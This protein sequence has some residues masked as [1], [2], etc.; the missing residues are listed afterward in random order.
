ME[1]LNLDQGFPQQFSA[2]QQGIAGLEFWDY[3]V[4]QNNQIDKAHSH[5][6]GIK[7]WHPAFSWPNRELKSQLIK[8]AQSPIMH[9][10]HKLIIGFYCKML[11]ILL[12]A[13]VEQLKKP[14]FVRKIFEMPLQKNNINNNF[15]GIPI[16]FTD[17]VL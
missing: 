4:L 8:V 12:G 14:T 17:S 2:V 5:I 15:T 7:N 13:M 11:Q 9:C 1:H 16:I 3:K 10:M 6:L